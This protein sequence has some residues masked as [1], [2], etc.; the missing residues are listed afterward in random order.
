MKLFT[1]WV[2]ISTRMYKQLKTNSQNKVST[3]LYAIET[4]FAQND[5]IRIRD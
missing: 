2:H 4:I 3:Q 5:K 1:I